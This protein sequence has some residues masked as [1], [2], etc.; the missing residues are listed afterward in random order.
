GVTCS[1]QYP[2]RATT[3]IG[4]GGFAAPSAPATE[5]ATAKTRAVATTGRA[6]AGKRPML[7]HLSGIASFRTDSD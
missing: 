2:P 4:S 6:P 1:R 7:L 3:V 5:I